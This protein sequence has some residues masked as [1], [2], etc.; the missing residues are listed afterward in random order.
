MLEILNA[1]EKVSG[2]KV[3]YEFAPRRAGDPPALYADSSKA[4]QELGWEVK[5]GDIEAIVA[6]AWT[7]HDK[8]PDGFGD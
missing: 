6:S 8:H 5:H 7:W 3:P 2:L 4:K 1:V